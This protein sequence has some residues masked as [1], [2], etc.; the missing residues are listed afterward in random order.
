MRR[1]AEGKGSL[2][3]LAGAA[4][5]GYLL[6]TVPSADAAARLATGGATDLRATGS[7][8]PGAANAMAALGKGWGYGIVG[9][10]I[11]KGALACMAGRALAGGTGANVAGTAA[12]V[13]HCYPVWNGFR[14]G[15][16]VAVSAGQCL[17]TFPAYLPL[18]LAV[19]W[20]VAHIRGKALPATATASA[21]WVTC[22]FLWWWRRWPNAWGP[23]PG[24]SLP[25]CSAVTSAVILGRFAAA[26][27]PS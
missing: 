4:V 11:A 10:D 9:A 14:G 22:G 13:G 24:P 20:A 2:S 18:D 27:R 3:A 25:L 19:A 1:T 21:L 16:G 7:G 17:A 8:N 26:K 15:K 23:E 12:V 6:G 5:A